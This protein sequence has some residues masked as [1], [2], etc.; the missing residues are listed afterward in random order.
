MYAMRRGPFDRFADLAARHVAHAWFFCASVLLV[1]MW[2]PSLLLIR[3]VDTWQLI[4]NTITTIVTFLLVALLQNTQQQAE[5]RAMAILRRI[6]RRV[7]A[8]EE[9]EAVRTSNEERLSRLIAAYDSWKP[10]E[11]WLAA[12]E[13]DEDAEPQN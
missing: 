2:L 12:E 6:E 5:D 13:G 7:G 9:S 11:L 10:T 1:V 3:D 4:I 8:D